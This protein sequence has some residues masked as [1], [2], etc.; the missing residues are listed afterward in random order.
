M[1][2]CLILL[3]CAF[4]CL[5]SV[6]SYCKFDIVS[7]LNET[8]VLK[9]ENYNVID[10]G[11]YYRIYK[12]N[13]TQVYYDIYNSDGQ[14]VLSETTDRPLRIEM[15]NDDI[16]DIRI[17]MGTGI[18]IHKYYDV[19][20]NI[21]SQDFTYVLSN[22]NELIA[23]IDVPNEKPFENRKV[24]VQ[25]VFDKSL[26]YKEFQL[27]FSKIDTPVVKA[28]FSNG[29]TSLELTYLSGEEQVQISETLVLKE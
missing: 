14:V 5:I 1:K 24:V 27:D 18:T 15:L 21:F 20:E 28:T 29:A 19:A 9:S 25:N 26:F 2:K 11:K 12:G 6:Y 4:V 23:F 8:K 10:S 16:V 7:S 3:V 13:V 17:G 22:S